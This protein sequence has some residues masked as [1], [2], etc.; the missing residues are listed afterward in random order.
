[1]VNSIKPEII[2]LR[3]L[4]L[5]VII[6]L[7]V[8]HQIRGH[9]SHEITF[10]VKGERNRLAWLLN[11]DFLLPFKFGKLHQKMIQMIQRKKFIE[12]TQVL[13]YGMV[14]LMG[15]HVRVFAEGEE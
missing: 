15:F 6:G 1:L 7:F 10:L 13:F 9:L 14:S 4:P 8:I 3:N 5:E 11:G 12:L 2:I